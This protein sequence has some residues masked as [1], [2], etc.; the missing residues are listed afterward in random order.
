MNGST[1]G[2]TKRGWRHALIAA[3]ARGLLG[4]VAAFLLLGVGG[5]GAQQQQVALNAAAPSG[6]AA[7]VASSTPR[8][9]LLG[10]GDAIR[11]VVFQNPDLTLE[12]RVSE[13]G[14]ITYP[15]VGPVKVGGLPLGEGE[16]R[17]ADALKKGGFVQ[18]P[19]VNIVLL[20]VRG[21][22]VAVLGQVN[23]PGRFP[24]ETT[25][26]RVSEALAQ[27]GGIAPTGAD[28]VIVMG[29][30]DGKPFRQEIDVASLYLN[31]QSE[32]DIA[33]A[34]GDT[35]YVHRAPMF[36]IYG[37]V[38]RPGAYRVE[39]NMTVMQALAQGGGPTVRGTERSLR[40]HRRN[41]QGILEKLSP[42]MDEAVRADDVLY[43]R[44][45]LF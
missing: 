20:Q 17:I 41:A 44:E 33:V 6:A 13:N 1:A 28:T 39:R 32:D 9:Y 8:E 18:M 36:Y 14:V 30:R 15:L 25:N 10:P 43:V 42:E 37:E 40:L 38:Q 35:L 29:T 23:R 19:Q 3:T 26:T 4:T 21:N 27:A 16:K 24:L 5:A 11:I 31:N 2:W 12:T 34:P 45:S 7:V 22:Q